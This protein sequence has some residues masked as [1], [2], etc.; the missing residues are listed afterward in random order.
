[1]A[2]KD[3][4]KTLGVSKGASQD[5]IRSSYRKLARKHHPD[6]NRDDPKAEGRFKEI[7]GAYEVLSNP[8][9][10]RQYDEGPRNFFGSGNAGGQAP[11][12]APPGAGGGNFTHV[13]DLSDLFGTFGDV[14]GGGARRREAPAKGTNITL[15]V[16]LKFKDA[17]EGVTT[18]LSVPVEE[19]CRACRG[20]GA[21]AGTAPKTCPECGGRGLRSRDQG[22]FALSEPCGR[23][24]GEGRVIETP[25]GV[26]RGS[27]R[28]KTTRSVTVKVPAGA[29][30]GMKIRVA[31]RGNAG[32]KGA[33]A[34]DLYVIT[35]VEAHPVFERKGDDFV[36]EAP[37][38][39]VEAALGAEVKVPRPS[40][41]SVTLKLPAG[42]QD[43]KQ[44]RVR[45]AGAPKPRE[46]GAGDLLVRVKVLVPKKLNRRERDILMALADE[47]D[48]DVREEL[49]KKAGA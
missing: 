25:C 24:G 11:G 8:E 29:R 1:M 15:S 37:V 27:G 18:R 47:R 46:G 19:E 4:Y 49:F 14:L 35:H 23:C 21:A 12:G 9:K 26:C 6:A 28:S 5:E 38:S 34:G 41:G 33:A 39:F 3:L 2:A 20:T 22:F 44:F 7:Q 36:I 10:R 48:E 31:G 43:G 16:N 30:E 40:G 32:T 45:G 13:S 17:L 42:T